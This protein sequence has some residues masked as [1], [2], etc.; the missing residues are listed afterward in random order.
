MST[1]SWMGVLLLC[2]CVVPKPGEEPGGGAVSDVPTPTIENPHQG[3][4]ALSANGLT[5]ALPTYN[6]FATGQQRSVTFIGVGDTEGEGTSMFFSESSPNAIITILTKRLR[7]S[8]FKSLP[9]VVTPDSPP[10]PMTMTVKDTELYFAGD[11]RSQLDVSVSSGGGTVGLD[12]YRVS[13]ETQTSDELVISIGATV[14]WTSNQA[15]LAY[16]RYDTKDSIGR[17]S[18][19]R[20]VALEKKPK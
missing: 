17:D 19:W 20:V 2:S 12:S 14:L 9:W 7:D 1:I 18:E 13:G 4:P 16:V 10:L 11:P 5:L 3:L 8:D 6:T 15:G